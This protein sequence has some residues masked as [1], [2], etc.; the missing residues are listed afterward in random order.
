MKPIL[1]EIGAIPIY[2]FGVMIVAAFFL[3][4]W[5]VTLELRR[6]GLDRQVKADSLV[7]SVL[8]GGLI[9]ARGYYILEN[10][11]EFLS[12]PFEIF[13]GGGLVWYGGVLGGVAALTYVVWKKKLNWLQTAD[14]LAPA[15]ALGYAI[16]RIGCLLA[17]DG[18]YGKP[19]NLPWAMAF[20]EGIVP[21]TVP[22]HP[23][24]IYEFLMMT[25]VFIVL[26]GMRKKVQKDGFIFGLYLILAGIERFLIEFL[27]INPV[28]AWN[29]TIAQVISLALSIIGWILIKG[30]VRHDLSPRY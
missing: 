2:S 11:S 10:F 5:I 9:G 21:T 16:G 7:I 4:S 6:K 8:L 29:L 20:P 25:A 27:R 17:G 26:W 18:D 22:V 19:S 14:I 1:I 24:P 23:T 13:S 12:A 3:C 15:L 28:V 30:Q